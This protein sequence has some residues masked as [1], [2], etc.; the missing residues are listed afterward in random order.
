M[1]SSP[2]KKK[3]ATRKSPK[4]AKAPAKRNAVKPRAPRRPTGE[5]TREALAW[6]ERHGTKKTRDGMAGY[7]ITA[8]K[9]FGVT[10]AD[11][12]VLAKKL[13]QNH[14][15]AVAL[16]NTGI[17]EARMLTA[18]VAEPQK[19]TAAQMDEWCRDFD[20]WAICDTLCFALFDRSPDAFD[21]VKSWAKSG[22]EFIKRAA[23][24]LLACLALH[25]REGRGE[26]DAPYLKLLPLIEQA[27]TDPRNF[28][29][30]A[31]N[32]ALR[33]IGGRSKPLHSEALEMA[34]RLADSPDAT[35]RWI[36]KDAE[37]A[38]EGS[39]TMKRLARKKG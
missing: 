39:A 22:E 13:G 28:V 18:F 35:A 6:L 37:K 24:A 25:N 8:K 3:A 4:S 38:L 17:Y 33:A 11:I 7:G 2:T 23:F 31:V 5:L 32:W 20:S 27:S 26:G 10:M 21:K 16:W 1:P 34:R 36:G 9:A 30:K 19:L 12:R 14:D 15:L 29:K